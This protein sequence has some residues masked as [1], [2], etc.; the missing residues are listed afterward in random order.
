M[1][2]IIKDIYKKYGKKEI[3]KGCSFTA[4]S[5][6]CIGILGENGCGKSTLLSVLA[7]VQ[8][9]DG[10]Q[11]LYGGEDLFRDQKKRR[12]LV[13]Y[14]PQGTPLMEE[15]SAL[16]NLLLWY[17]R[18]AMARELEQGVLARLGIRDFLKTPVHKLSGGM[19]KRLS[20]ACAVASSPSVLLLD[21]PM[22]ALD[23]SCKKEIFRYIREQKEMGNIVILVTHDI[24]E[25]KL[26]DQCYT[27]QGGIL[28]P[29]SPMESMKE[30]I[31]SL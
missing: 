1:E 26:C 8:E 20:I 7:G 19:K 27:L 28:R 16:D 2:I 25:L 17:D 24:P 15:L 3:L 13:G 21:E 10:G 9:A 11:F 23:L 31:G 4:K 29:E 22:A 18:K 12:R 30:L 5:G 6:S 14:V